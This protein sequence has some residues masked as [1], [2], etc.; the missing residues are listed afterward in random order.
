MCEKA[1]DRRKEK[2]LLKFIKI[3]GCWSKRLSVGLWKN[4][5]K[6]RRKKTLNFFTARTRTHKRCIIANV[7]Y[8][9]IYRGK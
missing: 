8:R 4:E 2:T 5:E 9:T 1:T 3:L 6:R 7:I